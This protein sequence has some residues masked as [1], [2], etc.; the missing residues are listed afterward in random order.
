MGHLGVFGGFV[1]F[2]GGAVFRRGFVD[3]VVRWGAAEA[4]GRSFA[5][6]PGF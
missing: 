1:V 2:V 4:F 3:G 5:S 6:L